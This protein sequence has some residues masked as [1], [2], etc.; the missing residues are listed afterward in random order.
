MASDVLLPQLVD[1]SIGTPEVG[2][3]NFNVL[4]KLLHA[5]VKTI[6]VSE[7]EFEVDKAFPAESKLAAG[8]QDV[9]GNTDEVVPLSLIAKVSSLEN[10]LKVLYP[11]LPNAKEMSAL[12]KSDQPI[13]DLWHLLALTKRIE[14]NAT[15]IQTAMDLIQELFNQQKTITTSLDN[16]TKQVKKAEL[17]SAD[18][19]ELKSVSSKVKRIESEVGDLGVVKSAKQVSKITTKV[20]K[21][22]N[23]DSGIPAN[24]QPRPESIPKLGDIMEKLSLLQSAI[25][26]GAIVTWPRLEDALNGTPSSS[27]LQTIPNILS[28][29]KPNNI[30]GKR[31]GGAEGIAEVLKAPL[32]G[33]TDDCLDMLEK[34]GTS[35]GKITELTERVQHLS[36]LVSDQDG[37][38]LTDE[39]IKELELLH[40]IAP[41][42]ADIEGLKSKLNDLEILLSDIPEAHD[43]HLPVLG[44]KSRLSLANFGPSPRSSHT[45]FY[46]FHP[47]SNTL[48]DKVDEP[49][50]D[51]PRSSTTPS[52]SAKAFISQAESINKSQGGLTDSKFRNSMKTPEDLSQSPHMPK[53]PFAKQKNADKIDSVQGN[54]P[55]STQKSDDAIDNPIIGAPE[56]KAFSSGKPTF[57][58]S[59]SIPSDSKGADKKKESNKVPDSDVSIPQASLVSESQTLSSSQ[60]D[61]K[62]SRPVTLGSKGVGS[63]SIALGSR[64]ATIK[65]EAN[66]VPGSSAPRS[67]SSRASD[68]QIF[69]IH[70]PASQESRTISLDSKAMD[71]KTGKNKVAVSKVPKRQ[72]SLVSDTQKRNSRKAVFKATGVRGSQSRELNTRR[73]TSLVASHAVDSITFES[74]SQSSL[75]T[76]SEI[77]A[78]QDLD[79]NGHSILDN[80]QVMNKTST[81]GKTSSDRVKRVDQ[82][83]VKTP[84]TYFQRASTPTKDLT[85]HSILPQID[86]LE[87][88]VIVAPNDQ[89]FSQ[90]I[91]NEED[92]DEKILLL[93]D[94]Q[95]SQAQ[96]EYLS[97]KMQHRKKASSLQP[98]SKRFTDTKADYQSKQSELPAG[99]S[100]PPIPDIKNRAERKSLKGYIT[101][102]TSAYNNR[103]KA[104]MDDWTSEGM[105]STA[106]MGQLNSLPDMSGRF[107]RTLREVVQRDYMPEI[108]RLHQR[109]NRLEDRP[110]YQIDVTDSRRGC[111]DS[112]VFDMLQKLDALRDETDRRV[113]EMND[114]LHSVLEQGPID[115]ES[116]RRTQIALG[117]LQAQLLTVRS[118]TLQLKS[119]NEQAATVMKEMKNDFVRLDEA[120]VDNH[121]LAAALDHKADYADL[122]HKV[123]K[124]K[125]ENITFDLHKLIDDLL[126]KLASLEDA[127][128]KAHQK[129]ESDIDAK[130]SEENMAKIKA[131]IE[132]KMKRLHRKIK[133]QQSLLYPTADEAAGL[134]RRLPFNCLSC[135]KPVAGY[136]YCIGDNLSLNK[137]GPH[138]LKYS[139]SDLDQLEALS[140]RESCDRISLSHLGKKNLKAYVVHL[141][142]EQQPKVFI[143]RSKTRMTTPGVAD[144]YAKP[145]ACGGKHTVT[146]NKL[147]GQI[148]QPGRT[149]SLKDVLAAEEFVAAGV[150]KQEEQVIKGADGRTYRSRNDTIEVDG[151]LTQAIRTNKDPSLPIVEELKLTNSSSL[152]KAV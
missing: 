72:A 68:T 103:Q 69:G 121:T 16:L 130:I 48:L 134:R 152:T 30:K 143:T 133:E 145:R 151:V 36:D 47:S 21:S 95:A 80:N 76:D 78:A 55:M 6:K 106:D 91:E 104:F 98:S 17:H 4:H 116:M 13:A 43:E 14:A 146:Q 122:A 89:T 96:P 60:P 61:S 35:P 107:N 86:S 120:K 81:S 128:K 125:L 20:G 66:K 123:D 32:V 41:D 33:P 65:A 139:Q 108:K 94:G 147:Q 126:A 79:V 83:K 24:P 141:C 44:D 136:Q 18:L 105:K 52:A 73:S 84:R 101:K 119:E 23:V 132:K 137:I 129:L 149:Q 142:K 109:I 82:P 8:K 138:A 117:D 90:S 70:K 26:D 92:D 15:G 37:A 46:Q 11:K 100:S 102:P 45:P 135:D 88:E 57:E 56:A 51:L 75:L 127:W 131:A 74:E 42:L 2:A 10:D 62:V 25:D 53:L 85:S 29:T 99:R 58:D 71:I 114:Q 64:A 144:A 9:A 40:R 63:H 49:F 150:L 110:A 140:P 3:V 87:S 50:E 19:I 39:T 28:A 97:P 7:L 124:A 34:L 112:K 115:E 31:S 22:S 12:I 1:L 59:H 77:Y 5:I 118:L 54:S 27:H 38:N 111:Q 93:D 67:R 148:V 113:R